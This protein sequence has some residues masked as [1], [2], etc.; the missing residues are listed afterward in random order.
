MISGYLFNLRAAGLF[1]LLVAF[2]AASASPAAQSRVTVVAFGLFGDQ[3][4]FESEAKGAARIVAN[5]F[6]GGPVI[7]RANTK[8]RGDATVATLAATLQSAAKGMDAENDILW[9][10]LTSHGSPAGLAVKAGSRQETLSPSVLV[11]MLNNTGVRHRVV[12]ISACYSGVFIPR[13]ADADTLVITAADAEHSSFGCRD[14]AE[15]TY[16]GD[17]FFNT[18]LRRTTNLKDA[19]ALARTLIRQRELRNG[20]TPSNPQMSG[21]E[22]IEPLLKGDRR[23]AIADDAE[24]M[25]LGYFGSASTPTNWMRAELSNWFTIGRPVFGSSKACPGL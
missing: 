12:I 13:L 3:S 20:F 24:A 16:F 21:G 19:F 14:R 6:G 15:W 2:F 5:R 7:V 9:L 1:V 25:R 17:A 4:V 18:A 23:G 11:T 10:I 22:N 8:R